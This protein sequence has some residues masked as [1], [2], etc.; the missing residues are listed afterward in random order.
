MDAS[1]AHSQDRLPGTIKVGGNTAEKSP[2][3]NEQETEFTTFGSSV[4]VSGQKNGD[5]QAGLMGEYIQVKD[6]ITNDRPVYK[7][8]TLDRFLFFA[9]RKK[10]KDGDERW[11]WWIGSETKMLTSEGGGYMKVADEAHTP[12]RITSTWQVGQPSGWLD[13]RKVSFSTNYIPCAKILE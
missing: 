7:H 12:D 6:H 3:P 4:F 1:D 10:N 11:H 13:T 2:Q 9:K 5:I 8:I